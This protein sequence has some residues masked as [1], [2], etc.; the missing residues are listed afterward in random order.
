MHL[1]LQSGAQFRETAEQL[2]TGLQAYLV[3]QLNGNHM[4]TK[5]ELFV[6]F[7]TALNFPSY[8]GKNWDALDECLS[9]LEW[10]PAR[11]Y[12]LAISDAPE[13][14]SDEP[15]EMERLLNVL[16]GA[17]DA[18]ASANAPRPFHV[19]FGC[20]PEHRSLMEQRLGSARYDVSIMA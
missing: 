15:Q 4:H 5:R 19:V 10:L 3:T 1:L 12:V 9:D 8:F 20:A 13:V 16:Q 6:E 7:A 11:S 18:W 17:G 14:L 2:T